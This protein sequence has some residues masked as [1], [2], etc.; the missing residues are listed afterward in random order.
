MNVRP[1]KLRPPTPFQLNRLQRRSATLP[2]IAE[3]RPISSKSVAEAVGALIWAKG[4]L[5][6]TVL[7][8]M[9]AAAELTLLMVT[10]VKAVVLLAL[11]AVGDRSGFRGHGDVDPG[12]GSF[13]RGRAGIDLDRRSDIYGGHSGGGDRGRGWDFGAHGR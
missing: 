4:P 13:S 7:L 12:R 2:S 5:V 1:R 11:E 10:W 3:A 9:E 8:A 6:E